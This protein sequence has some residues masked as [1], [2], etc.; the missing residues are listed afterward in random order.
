M[1]WK[2]GITV[3]VSALLNALKYGNKYEINRAPFNNISRPVPKFKFTTDG[4]SNK[5]KRETGRPIRQE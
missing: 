3:E 4:L 1:V 5:I 2:R